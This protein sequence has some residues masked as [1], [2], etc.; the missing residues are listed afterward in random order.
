M[1]VPGQKLFV[2]ANP[3]LTAGMGRSYIHIRVLIYFCL[4]RPA[5]LAYTFCAEMQ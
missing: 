4:Y 2:P 5:L 3:K 1:R